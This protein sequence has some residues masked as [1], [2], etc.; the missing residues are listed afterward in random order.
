M[1]M[2]S[3]LLASDWAGFNKVRFESNPKR[4]DIIIHLIRLRYSCE[5]PLLLAN[6]T[7]KQKITLPS[8]KHTS[9]QPSQFHWTTAVIILYSANEHC[10]LPRSN[11]VHWTFFL[12]F[13]VVVVVVAVWLS[14]SW[15]LTFHRIASKCLLNQ[16]KYS[17]FFIPPIKSHFSTIALLG[18]CCVSL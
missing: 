1:T 3:T 6:R 17:L 4:I 8:K 10:R 13:G 2:Y 7:E 5:Q 9:S 18:A 12:L 16:W 15:S 14:S 11:A